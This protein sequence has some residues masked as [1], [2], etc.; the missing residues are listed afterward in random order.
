[1]NRR[2]FF[3]LIGKGAAVAAVVPVLPAAAAAAP[4]A[5]AA[6][7][8]AVAAIVGASISIA[9]EMLHINTW[10]SPAM[11]YDQELQAI[12]AGQRATLEIDLVGEFPMLNLGDIV[13][14][15]WLVERCKDASVEFT[16]AQMP[17]DMKFRLVESTR[18]AEHGLVLTRLKLEEVFQ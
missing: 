8:A 16:F 10:G 4:A 2:N 1:M 6:A 15:P 14:R 3:K 12:E 9:R 18:T 11:P 13:D 7:P 5:S 17:S